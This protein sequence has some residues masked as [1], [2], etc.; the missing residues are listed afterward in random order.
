MWSTYVCTHSSRA[1]LIPSKHS[2]LGL[3]FLGIPAGLNRLGVIERHEIRL[4]VD[5]TADDNG[6]GKRGRARDHIRPRCGYACQILRWIGIGGLSLDGGR[7]PASQPASRL[8]SSFA[9]F[10]PLRP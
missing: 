9:G 7:E 10:L 6:M 1:L 5:K 3:S 2:K 4:D 8:F